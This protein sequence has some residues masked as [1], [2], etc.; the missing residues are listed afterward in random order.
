MG[1]DNLNDTLSRCRG[2]PG[3]NDGGIIAQIKESYEHQDEKI[4]WLEAQIKESDERDEEETEAEM[5]RQ[6]N[7]LQP[8]YDEFRE[9]EDQLTEC[10]EELEEKLA[11]VGGSSSGGAAV[12]PK[13]RTSRR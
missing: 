3:S 5:T 2:G 9:M 1:A 11:L 8:I 13:R 12:E 6:R 10:I 4:Q 7:A